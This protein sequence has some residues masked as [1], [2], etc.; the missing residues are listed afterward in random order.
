M[1]I[2]EASQAGAIVIGDKG[3]EI[4]IAFGMVEKAAVVGGAVLL[5]AVEVV[6]E[7]AVEPLDHAIGLRPAE[8]GGRGGG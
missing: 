3:G 1:S 5:V 8:T 7:A 4:G 6:T 2:A